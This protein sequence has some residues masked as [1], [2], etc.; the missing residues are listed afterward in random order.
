M[1]RA[2]KR[3]AVVN[4]KALRLAGLRA[5]WRLLAGSLRPVLRGDN[6]NANLHYADITGVT[7]GDDGRPRPELFVDD[8]LHLTELGYLEWGNVV[9]PIVYAAEERYRRLKGCDRWGCGALR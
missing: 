1:L 5:G 3:I 6:N 9:K 4:K 8:D 2:V 7:L